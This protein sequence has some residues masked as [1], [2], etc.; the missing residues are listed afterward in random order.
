MLGSSFLEEE[1]KDVVVQVVCRVET[2]ESTQ[3]QS[4]DLVR[5]RAIRILIDHHHL[6]SLRVAIW[7]VTG[8]LGLRAIPLIDYA[9]I[10][11][12]EVG[13]WLKVDVLGT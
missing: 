4:G 6:V 11:H 10:L 3:R 8:E 13:R 9:G 2:I 12:D 1:V 5:D 7:F